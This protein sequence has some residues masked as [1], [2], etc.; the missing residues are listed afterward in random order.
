MP[1]YIKFSCN[2]I[3]IRQMKL[4]HSYASQPINLINKSAQLGADCIPYSFPR[5]SKLKL[6]YVTVSPI[7]ALPTTWH[8]PEYL[9]FSHP[10]RSRTTRLLSPPQ[11]SVAG[12]YSSVLTCNN[13]FL[14]YGTAN[15]NCVS[16]VRLLYQGK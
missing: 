10:P 8:L 15:R 2:I 16:M 11:K 12:E 6:I 7:H 9:L 1:H 14:Y 3:K 5:I 4:H 13:C